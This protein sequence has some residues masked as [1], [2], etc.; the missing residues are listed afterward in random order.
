MSLNT[1]KRDPEGTVPST[2]Q[3]EKTEEEKAEEKRLKAEQD[4]EAKYWFIVS[5]GPKLEEGT[6]I[7][8]INSTWVKEWKVKTHCKKRSDLAESLKTQGVRIHE[9]IRI[10]SIGINAEILKKEPYFWPTYVSKG[11]KDGKEPSKDKD[12][13]EGIMKP[14]LVL[15]LDYTIVTEALYNEL[16]KFASG[17]PEPIRRRYKSGLSLQQLF[18]PFQVRSI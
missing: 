15:G 12:T 7:H 17:K 16:V 6:M 9:D 8:A 13:L 18:Y 14:R 3:K 11:G 1:P 4:C 2:S 10:D 5:E